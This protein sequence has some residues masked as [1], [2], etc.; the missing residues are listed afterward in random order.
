MLYPIP[1][2][3]I[4]QIFLALLISRKIDDHKFYEIYKHCL[5]TK[6]DWT[7]T[8]NIELK[9]I[10]QSQ[11]IDIKEKRELISFIIETNVTNSLEIFSN[12]IFFLWHFSDESSEQITEVIL[13]DSFAKDSRL[14]S[15]IIQKV[16][17]E[18]CLVNWFDRQGLLLFLK[19]FLLKKLKE[20]SI[21]ITKTDA[22]E[23]MT[24]GCEIGDTL[25]EDHGFIFFGE[26]Q[27]SYNV[28]LYTEDEQWSADIVPQQEIDNK[29]F[30]IKIRP[31]D[32][33]TEHFEDPEE[34]FDWIVKT[35]EEDSASRLDFENQFKSHL[36]SESQSDWRY[37]KC[38]CYE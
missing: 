33:K 4:R 10:L 26:A 38:R 21:Q 16:Y 12:I 19:I 9:L 29:N 20:C 18:I 34:L 35:L 6:L 1:T 5:Q 11:H 37:F 32:G 31:Y 14:Y 15:K 17:S 27:E 30:P 25:E 2:I 8:P 22:I 3:P 28:F 36:W 23:L 7:T 13:N 24:E